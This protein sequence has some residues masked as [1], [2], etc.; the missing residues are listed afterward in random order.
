MLVRGLLVCNRTNCLNAPIDAQRCA[1][2]NFIFVEILNR[3]Q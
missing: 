1:A 3:I 2:E